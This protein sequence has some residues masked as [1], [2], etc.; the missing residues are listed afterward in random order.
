MALKKGKRGPEGAGERVARLLV[1]IPWLLERGEAEIAQVAKEFK[2]SEKQV[3]ADLELASVCG[4]PPFSPLELIDVYVDGD[5]AYAGLP[6]VIHR[7]L[8][9]NTAELFALMTMG[10]AALATPGADRQG[11]LSRAL[12]KLRPLMPRDATPIVVDLPRTPFVEEVREAAIDGE[13]LEIRYFTPASGARTTRVITPRN[14]FERGGHWYV[15]ADDD[16]SGERREFRLDRIE[17]LTRTGEFD[18]K[19]SEPHE[20][21][22]WFTET[23]TVVTLQVAPGVRYLVDSYPYIERKDH[24][25][26]SL[27]VQLGVSS[28]HWLG[29]LLIRGGGDIE[30]VGGTAPADLR[31]TTARQVLARYSQ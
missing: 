27:T 13:R 19:E 28:E 16:R 18:T 7:P 24:R 6:T 8:K 4:A 23:G 9:M 11:P 2:I 3:V 31:A 22:N 1:L 26:G 12:E 30:V 25:D 5:M 10:A 17:E 29:R 21:A 20:G 15:S 14:V